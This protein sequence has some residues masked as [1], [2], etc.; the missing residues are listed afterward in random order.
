[1]PDLYNRALAKIQHWDE[2]WKRIPEDDITRMIGLLRALLVER[3]A[4]FTTLG[5][6]ED[7]AAAQVQSALRDFAGGE[8]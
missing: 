4:R 8:R 2:S 5:G 6:E 1:M 7:A 3:Q